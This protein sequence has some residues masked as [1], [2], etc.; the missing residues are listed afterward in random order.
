MAPTKLKSV[1]GKTHLGLKWELVYLSIHQPVYIYLS[2]SLS[3][4]IDLFGREG[5]FAG[6]LGSAQH[7]YLRAS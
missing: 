4:Y 2:T 6:E 7:K 1:D 3:I 5:I